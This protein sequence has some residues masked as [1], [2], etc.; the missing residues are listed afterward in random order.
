MQVYSHSYWLVFFCT[1]NSSRVLARERWQTFENSWKKTQYLMN[2]LYL[3]SERPGFSTNNAFSCSTKWSTNYPWIIKDKIWHFWP[4]TRP[5]SSQD[6][7]FFIIIISALFVLI[8]EHKFPLFCSCL[9]ALVEVRPK[10]LS[11]TKAGLPLQ[12]HSTNGRQ[13]SSRPVCLR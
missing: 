9:F 10:T 1:T 13:H 12:E 2:T 5:T 6:C 11:K 4:F 7:L 3:L 8:G